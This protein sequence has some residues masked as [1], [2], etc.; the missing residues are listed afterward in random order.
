MMNIGLQ[1]TGNDAQNL[2]AQKTPGSDD[3]MEHE[4]ASKYTD[5]YGRI[6]TTSRNI[7]PRGLVEGV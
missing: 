2:Q 1:N 3:I 7:L 4:V 6:Y 5:R